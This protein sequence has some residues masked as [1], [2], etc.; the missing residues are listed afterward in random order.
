MLRRQL[1]ML[2]HLARQ[3]EMLLCSAQGIHPT[4][5][6]RDIHSPSYQLLLGAGVSPNTR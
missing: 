1:P 3:A 4:A 5:Q 2:L 6:G